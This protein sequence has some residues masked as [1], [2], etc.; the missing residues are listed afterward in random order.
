MLK[1]KSVKFA[2]LLHD[3]LNAM[4]DVEKR[5]G[6][7]GVKRQNR[8]IRYYQQQYELLSETRRWPPVS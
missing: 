4:P 8:L 7:E 5:F 3:L 6:K 1:Q 2:H